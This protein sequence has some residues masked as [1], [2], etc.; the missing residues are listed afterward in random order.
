MEFLHPSKTDIDQVI[1]L[2]VVAKKKKTK[3]HCYI[4]DYRTGLRQASELRSGQ[5]IPDDERLPLLLIPLRMSA[6]FM[7]VTQ[8]H[9]TVY[10]GIL[11][12]PATWH[13]HTLQ[14]HE[15]PEQPGSSRYLPIFSQWARVLRNENHVKTRDNIYLCREDG[16]V[17]FLEISEISDSM[18][19]SQ[20]EAGQLNV[21][22]N[23]AFATL[24][25]GGEYH[26]LLVVGGDLSNGVLFLFAPR[27]GS[28]LM[29]TIPNW[30][31]M[32]DIAVTSV[33]QPEASTLPLAGSVK[34]HM[35][36]FA[37]TG[38]GPIHGEITEI[39]YGIEGAIV[40]E[41]EHVGN[42]VTDIWVLHDSP[43]KS[44]HVVVS[45]P[46]DTTLLTIGSDEANLPDADS[47][48]ELEYNAPTITTGLTA[49]GCIVQVTATTIL[50]TSTLDRRRRLV[51]DMK[52]ESVTSA[53]IVTSST[54]GCILLTT[55]Q[56][57]AGNY[58]QCTRIRT[59][60]EEI[61][62]QHLGDPVELLT[63]PSCSSLQEIRGRICAFVG[64]LTGSLLVFIRSNGVGPCLQVTFKHEF[65]GDFAVCDSIATIVDENQGWLVCG[66]RNG[67]CQTL[68]LASEG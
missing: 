39:R 46:T 68:S 20:M 58:L 26:D 44:V 4:W 31:P 6:A 64:L 9:I 11:T 67:S 42:A 14:H 15:D 66:L 47:Q 30:T 10:T 21:N 54:Y 34:D 60:S 57:E 5:P 38:R 40:G 63:E 29:S 62:L 28:K 1:L 37:S 35:R 7:L 55:M 16:V 41:L 59:D 27:T 33:K 13:K 24:H 43:I 45:S 12:G 65:E 48:I 23:T 22:T 8:Q 18:I 49:E 19:D 53:S 25:L 61:F 2:V 50:I 56:R 36:V 52:D 17:R 51:V 3:L 32:M